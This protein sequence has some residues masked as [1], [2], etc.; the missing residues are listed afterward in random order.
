[1]SETRKEQPEDP[2][3]ESMLA[4]SE[5]H[6]RLLH[7]QKRT[8]RRFRV[9]TAIMLSI[10]AVATAWSG[11]QAARWGG[12][13]STKYAQASVLRVDLTRHSTL[14]G[15]LRPLRY[16]RRQQLDH[17]VYSRQYDTGSSL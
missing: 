13:Q 12:L 9:I 4:F 1:M 5:Q 11:Y 17:R 8:E 2:T 16:H 14:A 3:V 10:V 6:I 15:Q 7:R